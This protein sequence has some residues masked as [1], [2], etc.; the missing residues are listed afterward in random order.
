MKA[1]D[2]IRLGGATRRTAALALAAL[3]LG[4][5][6]VVGTPGRAEA[7]QCPPGTVQLGIFCVRDNTATT[8]PAPATTTTT[9]PA[10][11]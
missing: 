6:A 10:A 5:A 1:H 2:G 9:A 8:V 11:P 3:C 7:A 4:A